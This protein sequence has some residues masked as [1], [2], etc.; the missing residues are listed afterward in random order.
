M[1]PKQPWTGQLIFLNQ[2]QMPW[3]CFK[4]NIATNL[5][6]VVKFNYDP[7]AGASSI[8]SMEDK[9]AGWTNTK[10]KT[11]SW[12]I[13]TIRSMS[14]QGDFLNNLGHFPSLEHN[15]MDVCQ[16]KYSQ[17][18][19]TRLKCTWNSSRGI[20]DCT[21]KHVTGLTDTKAKTRLLL[22]QLDTC[23]FK[24]STSRNVILF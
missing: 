22:P 12:F 6:D 7:L 16:A 19:R 4:P 23:L 11:C 17:T 18:W 1:C 13:A 10:P 21:Q 8:A 5:E 9:W 20:R 14:C 15:K 2:F 3:W 24:S